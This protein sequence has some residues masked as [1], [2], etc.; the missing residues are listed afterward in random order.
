MRAKAALLAV[1]L[2]LAA[3]S[4][5]VMAQTLDPRMSALEPLLHKEWRGMMKALDGGP[6]IEI[7]LR[8]EAVGAGLLVKY[9]RKS[10]SRGGLTEG[11]FY[12]DDLAKKI[13]CF[14]VHSGG[15][16]RTGSVKAE[17][18]VLTIEGRMAWPSA[19]QD[20]QVKPAYDFRDTFS[21]ASE[22]KM[23]DRWFQNAFGPWRPGHEIVFEAKTPS[24]PK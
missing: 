10:T 11:F 21:F 22:S 13:A 5:T 6:D 9:E 1:V 4:P 17:S 20:P 2:L 18:G 3:V 16:F 15:S 7:V 23:T 12:W 24:V 14:S 19:P 8:F